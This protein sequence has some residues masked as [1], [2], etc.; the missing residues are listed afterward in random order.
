[1]ELADVPTFKKKVMYEVGVKVNGKS[2]RIWQLEV[3][4]NFYVAELTVC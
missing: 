2:V 1:M 4:R 3:P